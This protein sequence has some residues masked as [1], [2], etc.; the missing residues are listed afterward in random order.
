MAEVL[1][2]EHTQAV[3]DIYR[4]LIESKGL[5]VRV[6]SSAEDGIDLFTRGRPSAVLMELVLPR[7]NGIELL[8]HIRQQDDTSNIPVIVSTASLS[9][10]L[11]EQARLEG[12]TK[13]LE[14]AD[15]TPKAT[16]DA[17]LEAMG[18]DPKQTP[19]SSHKKSFARRKTER[20]I[21]SERE[22]FQTSLLE[23]LVDLLTKVPVE[24]EKIGTEEFRSELVEY[25]EKLKLSLDN[26]DATTLIVSLVTMCEDYFHRAR[27]FLKDKDDQFAEIVLLL[28]EAAREMANAAGALDQ[29]IDGTAARFSRLAEVDDLQELKKRVAE[30]VTVLKEL[31]ARKHQQEKLTFGKLAEQIEGLQSKL[32]HAEHELGIDPLTQVA[33]RG[34]F[35]RVIVDWIDR[36]RLDGTS[37]VL[38]VIDL[39]DF[40]KINDTY[41]HTIGD[42]ALRTTA[43]WLSNAVRASDFV[44][45]YG[46]EEFIVL[47]EHINLDRAGPRLTLLL[48]QL[49]VSRYK[50]ET[51]GE[52]CSLRISAS[53]GVAQ[54]KDGDSVTALISR[55]DAA[56]YK[57]KREGKNR[58]VVERVEAAQWA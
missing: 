3:A 14:K 6:A 15:Y 39:D 11:L 45:R 29:Q 54:Y 25:R 30:E 34:A 49:A 22:K 17:L 21:D 33:N 52:S 1:V 43:D 27:V 41:G 58:V 12:A 18:L 44:A 36:H 38:A 55:A 42:R 37:F 56:M 26:V 7:L 40:K 24:S 35:D 48:K 51:D 32:Q 46:G 57:A 8:R 16:V 28:K 50:F 31:L 23:T 4:D 53:C 9:R 47:L 20:I 5:S 13:V 19:E 10:K 2:V